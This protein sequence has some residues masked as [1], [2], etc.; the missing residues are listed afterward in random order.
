MLIYNSLTRDKQT[1]HP[2][3]P[4]KVRMYVCGMT[5]Y[6][7]CHLGHA[8]VMVVFDMAYRWLKTSGFEVNYVCNI[9]DIDDQ[10]IK[11]AAEKNEPIDALTNRFIQ[12]MH[13]DETRLGILPPT[14][15]PRATQFV[16]G[17]VHMIQT[18]WTKGLRTRRR[19]A[20]CITPCIYLKATASSP[21]NLWTTCAPASASMWTPTSAIR[22]TLYYGKRLSLMSRHGIRP[23]VRAAPAGISN[24]R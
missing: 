12:F 4:G 16:P 17:M 8:R 6:D 18:L 15:E 3:T 2:I 9:T 23:G 21:A 5:V 19:T 10:I 7:F 13:E 11:R 24:V 20:M 22:S 14:H 1:V